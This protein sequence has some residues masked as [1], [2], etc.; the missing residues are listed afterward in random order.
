MTPQPNGKASAREGERGFALV[1][2]L[3][4]IVVLALQ[5]SVFN[6]AV[7]DSVSL[8]DNETAAQRGQSLLHAGIEAAVAKML[9]GDPRERWGA[10]GSQRSIQI[11]DA[12]VRV[13]ISDE[14]GRI[15]L[16][17]AEPELLVSLFKTLTGSEADARTVA[18][19]VLDWR[20]P[21]SDRR[22]RGAEANDYRRAGLEWGAADQPFLDTTDIGKVL[23][24]SAALA[25]Q[26]QPF[27][28]IYT[29]DGRVNPLLASEEVLRALPGVRPEDM[30]TIRALRRQ[31]GEAALGIAAHLRGAQ[32]FV[33]GGR[34]PAV[35][36]QVQVQSARGAALAKGEAILVL[37]LDG[38]SPYR[39]LAWRT[40]PSTL[41]GVPAR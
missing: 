12:D 33:G 1:I 13:R 14:N 23:G 30:E 31:G 3:W 41:G 32:Q 16:N 36:I 9:A 39:V 2:V 22:E 38:A 37:G 21:D 26:I 19:R 8:S 4:I 18:D 17:H 5:V 40:E 25:A 20:D 29:K 15:N 34:G 35:R 6:A 11:G 28:T 24:V 27:V 10:D 7:R